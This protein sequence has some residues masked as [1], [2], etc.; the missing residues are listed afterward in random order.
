MNKRWQIAA[1]VGS[2]FFALGAGYLVHGV[3]HKDKPASLP[4]TPTVGENALLASKFLD[5]NGKIYDFDDLAGQVLVINFWATWC[6]PC[7][8]EVPEFVKLQN[9]YREQGLT[10]IGIA[11]DNKENILAFVDEVGMN[12]PILLGDLAAI[13]LSRRL[14]NRFGALP[15]TTFLNRTHTVATSAS[16][17][18]SGPALEAI[19]EKLLVK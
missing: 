12:Y 2:A 6:A 5:L 10:V 16:G 3:T 4:S 8:K 1:M 13:E 19:V 11:I 18:V 17:A 9:K 7:R 15:F 14:G